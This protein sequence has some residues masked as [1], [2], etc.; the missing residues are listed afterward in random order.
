[1]RSSC[2]CSFCLHLRP[3]RAELSLQLRR[4]RGCVREAEQE[5]GGHPQLLRGSS[6]RVYA[7]R[8]AAV[9]DLRDSGMV[10]PLPECG[11]E[12]GLVQPRLLPAA[13]ES[14]ADGVVS[15]F[16]SS[17]TGYE[18]P[19]PPGESRPAVRSGKP[20]CRI[21]QLRDQNDTGRA[22][23]RI[24]APRPAGRRRRRPPLGA[25]PQT[26][27]CR[28][29]STPGSNRR[30]TSRRHLQRIA[31]QSVPGCVSPACGVPLPRPP[32]PA[33]PRPR[34]AANRPPLS[35]G[36][37][38]SGTSPPVSCIAPRPQATRPT[39]VRRREERATFASHIATKS[40]RGPQEVP[41]FL[42]HGH[43]GRHRHALRMSICT[44]RMSLLWPPAGD[45]CTKQGVPRRRAVAPCTG[46][47][48]VGRTTR[49]GA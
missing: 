40:G 41:G 9:L 32:G 10:E 6:Q 33:P 29:P 4:R 18:V 43:A 49:S 26:P 48:D 42:D 28:A 11:S 22:P 34:P 45:R 25:S 44:F 7:H 23:G 47:R 12:F 19:Y 24:A 39:I 27:P 17:G 31:R 2:A 5:V 36:I 37:A 46:T 16:S 14:L 13:R 38:P 1:M 21:R 35:N 20:H 30:E 3:E 15:F 8:A